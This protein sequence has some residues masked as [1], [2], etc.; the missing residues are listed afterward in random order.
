MAT[1]GPIEDDYIDGIIKS[2]AQGDLSKTSGEGLR[3]LIK[4]LRDRTEQELSNVKIASKRLTVSTDAPSGVPSDG[5][6]WVV[7]I[8]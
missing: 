8:P 3:E 1:I 7:Y 4:A 6:E 5:E 2:A